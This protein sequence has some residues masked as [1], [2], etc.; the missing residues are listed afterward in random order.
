MVLNLFSTTPPLSISISFQAPPLISRS[1]TYERTQGLL[2]REGLD[3]RRAFWH[4]TF[5]TWKCKTL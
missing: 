2:A 1:K 4:V 3:A 5:D